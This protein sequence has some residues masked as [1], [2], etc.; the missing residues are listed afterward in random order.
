[1]LGTIGELT[2]I[3]YSQ[4]YTIGGAKNNFWPTYGVGIFDPLQF[5]GMFG[6]GAILDNQELR[7]V[8][9]FP[10]MWQTFNPSRTHAQTQSAPLPIA[11]EPNASLFA[12]V[13]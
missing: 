10:F 11:P 13:R 1:M 7:S 3:Q 8:E 6:Y 5:Q 9:R 12:L 2:F 4:P